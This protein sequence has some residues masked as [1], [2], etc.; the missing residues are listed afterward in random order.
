MGEIR[1]PQPDKGCHSCGSN[2]W[3]WPDDSYVGKREWLCSKCHPKPR[4]TVN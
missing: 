4:E 3:Y 1:P 2:D